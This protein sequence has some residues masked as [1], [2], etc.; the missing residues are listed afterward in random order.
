MLERS[1]KHKWGVKYERYAIYVRKQI[2]FFLNISK[3]IKAKTERVREEASWPKIAKLPASANHLCMY[4]HIMNHTYHAYAHDSLTLPNRQALMRIRGKWLYIH[5]NHTI[6]Y[7]H[8][9][10]T[11]GLGCLYNIF[12]QTYKHNGGQGSKDP[13][14]RWTY[15][16]SYR[17]IK[18]LK[19]RKRPLALLARRTRYNL[20][21][22]KCC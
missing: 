15:W 11:F 21:F 13:W 10:G 20:F 7:I 8:S 4:M 5:K 19:K 18:K 6:Q 3:T 16:C 9:W 14:W 17:P 1:N 22:V 12:T 2:L